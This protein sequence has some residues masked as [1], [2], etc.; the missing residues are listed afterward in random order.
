[1]GGEQTTGACFFGV[2]LETFLGQDEAEQ[3]AD[4]FVVFDD[5]TK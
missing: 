1:M 3:F 4:V 2:N 5:Q